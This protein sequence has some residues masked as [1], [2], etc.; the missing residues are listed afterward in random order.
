VLTCLGIAVAAPCAQAQDEL[1][2]M[3]GSISSEHGWPRSYAWSFSYRNAWA[4]HFST[5]VSYLND[6]HFPAHHRDGITG[7]VWAQT[8]LLDGHLTL[9]A[10]GGPFYYYDTTAAA[11]STG[12]ADDHGWA[13][14]Y[15]LGAT[16]QAGKRG[17][18]LEL[19]IDRTAP[20]KSIATTSVSLGLG[21]RLPSDFRARERS[22]ASDQLDPNEATAF[23]G[24]TVVNSFHSEASRAA[25]AEF[26]RDLWREVRVSVAFVNEGD[27]R[28][29]RRSGGV[30]EGWLEPS[31]FAG[32]YSVGIGFGGYAAIDKYRPTPGRRVSDIVSLTMSY[33]LID[34][35]DARFNWHRIVTDYSRDTDIVLFGLGYRF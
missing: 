15:S 33:R 35:L 29:I 25:A 9:L 7:E 5:T 26:R 1:S 34:H 32:R 2:L 18:F 3:A 16:V 30:F 21:Y 28:L 10:G 4:E 13:W 31:F 19:R 22:E 6:G 17:G 23:Y 24:K 12:Y 14:L 8:D 20:A 27:A 11:H